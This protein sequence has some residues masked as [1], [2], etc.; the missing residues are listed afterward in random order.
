[1]KQTCGQTSQLSPF[2]LPIEKLAFLNSSKPIELSS[3]P[4]SRM[5]RSAMFS[6]WAGETSEPTT[7]RRVFRGNTN[8]HEINK[9][10]DYVRDFPNDSKTT[11][12]IVDC[13]PESFTF[14]SNPVCTR[15]CCNLRSPFSV[16][17]CTTT[18]TNLF[19]IN[20]SELDPLVSTANNRL[21]II[22]LA[23]TLVDV[24]LYF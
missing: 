4:E 7:R 10:P 14:L 15:S 8:T 1:M 5:V 17:R 22:N 6:S 11:T 20:G 19:Y 24:L 21:N 12:A 18:F 16:H 9:S 23:T 2:L 3:L 13:F